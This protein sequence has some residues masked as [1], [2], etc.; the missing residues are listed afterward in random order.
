MSLRDLIVFGSADDKKKAGFLI[1]GQ[2][3]NI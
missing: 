1:P 2:V 3:V